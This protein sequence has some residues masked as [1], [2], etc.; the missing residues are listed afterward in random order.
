MFD[1][2]LS[3]LTQLLGPLAELPFIGDFITQLLDFIG[4]LG[5]SES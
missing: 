3:L 5:G 1:S 4:G 2:I